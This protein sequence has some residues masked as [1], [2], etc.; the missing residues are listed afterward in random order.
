MSCSNSTSKCSK[1]SSVGSCN[2]SMGMTYGQ[3]FDTPSTHYVVQSTFPLVQDINYEDCNY[4][5]LQSYSIKQPA[6]SPPMKCNSKCNKCDFMDPEE[7]SMLSVGSNCDAGFTWSG[8]KPA[9]T[10]GPLNT[11]YDRFA[12]YAPCG[13]WSSCRKAG[14]EPKKYFE[15]NPRQ[16][17]RGE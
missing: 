16:G 15:P 8:S 12:K 1:S 17:G 7:A 10:V 14:C 2:A 4:P 5:K 13:H 3:G 6:E 11:C 9:K